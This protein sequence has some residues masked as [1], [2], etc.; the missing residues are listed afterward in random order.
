MKM[1]TEIRVG[2]SKKYKQ[3]YNDLKEESVVKEMHETFFICAVLGHRASRRSKIADRDDRF[4]SKTFEPHEWTTFY[5]LRLQDHNQDITS[6]ADDKVVIRDMEEY[7]N[8]GMEI[9]ISEF[10]HNYLTSE[11]SEPTL[12]KTHSAE[13]AKDLLHYLFNQINQE[14][15]PAP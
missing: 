3:L 5:A 14:T 1:D 8:A 15:L 6:I 7:A 12:D 10:L 2:T 9:L 11:E 4:W 13:L